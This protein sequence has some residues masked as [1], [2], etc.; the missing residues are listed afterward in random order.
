MNNKILITVV[1]IALLL[2]MF[3]AI[4]SASRKRK[5]ELKKISDSLAIGKNI[6]TTGGIH[7]SIV[8]IDENT[9]NVKID[10]GVSITLS[11]DSI[12]WVQN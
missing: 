12:V 7:G 10:K 9:V 4:F 11:K 1:Y 2:Y 6:I 5:K 3:Y 8:K